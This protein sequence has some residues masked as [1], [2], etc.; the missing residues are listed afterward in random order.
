MTTKQQPVVLVIRD[1]WGRNPDSS[2]D[3][4]NAILQANTPVADALFQNHPTTMIETSG[5]SVGL[6][7]GV[8]GN[9]E[10]GHQNI[11]AGRIVPQELIRLSAAAENGEFKT[12][13]V[14]SKALGNRIQLQVKLLRTSKA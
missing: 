2:M 9:S 3:S 5:T 10:V 14:I 11:G 6:P 8:M 4:H 7:N 12:N 1:G 13:P